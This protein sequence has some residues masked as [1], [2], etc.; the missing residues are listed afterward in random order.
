[1]TLIL[2]RKHIA[3]RVYSFETNVPA[4]NTAAVITIAAVAGVTPYVSQINFSLSAAPAAPAL[5]SITDDTTVVWSTNVI[6]GGPGVAHFPYEFA[7]TAG[8]KLVITLSAGGAA[9]LGVVNVQS[10]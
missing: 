8:N 4:A 1:M 9:V 10:R 2:E 3:G 6:A 7:G 5:L